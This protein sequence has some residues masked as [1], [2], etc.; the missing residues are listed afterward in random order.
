MP[1]LH[2]STKIVE[3]LY[4]VYPGL[5]SL[6]GTAGIVADVV[7]ETGSVNATCCR[8]DRFLGFKNDVVP[9]CGENCDRR[10]RKLRETWSFRREIRLA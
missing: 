9:P 1:V 10:G 4:V 8:L 3:Q 6:A 5:K 7:A 2:I